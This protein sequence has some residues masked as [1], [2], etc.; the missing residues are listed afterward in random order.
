MLAA[1]DGAGTGKDAADAWSATCRRAGRLAPYLVLPLAL[2][3]WLLSLRS[4]D[5]DA[6]NDL[7]L[8]Q[9]LPPLYWIAVVLL[10]VGFWLALRDRRVRTGWLTAY[11]LGLIAMIHA[12][13]SLLYPSLRY[14]WAWKHIA[15]L[16][17]MIRNDGPVPHAGGFDI[18]NQ[19][20][21][22]FVL[23][24]LFLRV[25][26][27][28]SALGY[29]A[30]APAATNALLLAPLLLLYRT[31]STERRL[32]WGALWIYYC[33]AWVG[34][35]YFAPQAFAFLLFLTVLV[36][37]AG[38]LPNG[39]TGPGGT[40]PSLAPARTAP[41][42]GRLPAILLLEAAIVVSHQLTPLM[43]L[44]A[45]TALALPRRNRRAVLP[46]LAG[47]LVL[48]GV[49]YATVA[50]PF[51]SENLSDFVAGLTAPESNILSGLVGLGAAAPGQVVVAWV[52]R[53]LSATVV[54][55]ALAAV[56]R[57]PWVRR[58]A[59]PLLAVAPM[60][61]LA[62]NSYGGEMVFRVYLF[63]LPACAFLIAALLRPGRLPGLR[64][65]T[66]MA[67]AL[68]LL[69]GLFFG[70][71]SKEDMNYFTPGEVTAA[72]RM[73][74]LAPPG[75][76]IVSVTGNLPG[77][78]A[79]YDLHPRIQLSEE[80]RETQQLLLAD[81][82]AGLTRAADSTEA[83]TPAYLLLNRA[84]AAECYLTGVLPA[85]T[86]ARLGTAVDGAPRFTVVYRNDDAVVYRFVPNAA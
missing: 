68:A 71:Y 59:L 29:A 6:M 33:C 26:G 55:L 66:S 45:L 51:L 83:G 5:L 58:T 82:L 25:T 80:S 77:G 48:N 23:N 73:I 28:E 2:L 79:E 64:S 86:V 81:P 7:G 31:F 49:W 14:A 1:A 18:Y 52:D 76:V 15:V 12:T 4:V 16:D 41:S 65:L 19:W 43:L 39:G 8:L 70:Y 9:V 35:D 61:L 21:G 47:L 44:C 60:P 20:P 17:A 11:L 54:L 42:R 67:V 56:W 53:G 34:Q 38:Q 72:R 74:A 22:F 75:A 27:M 78:A 62:A 63:A 69:G 40:R 32:V 37:V 50:R 24:G 30:W 57:R 46:A 36:L 85:D 10:T 84:Q 3:L 13:P